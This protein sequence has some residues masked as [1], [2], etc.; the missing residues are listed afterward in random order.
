M[1]LNFEID[2]AALT[3]EE[4]MFIIMYLFILHLQVNGIVLNKLTCYK[5]R[6]ADF[7]DFL[8]CLYNLSSLFFHFSESNIE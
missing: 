7:C 3:R 5:S 1:G 8:L 6:L 2:D 4:K